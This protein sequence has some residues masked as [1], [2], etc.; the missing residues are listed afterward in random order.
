MTIPETDGAPAKPATAGSPADGHPRWFALRTRA[1]HEKKVRDEV[2]RAGLEAFL[3]LWERWSQWKDRRRLVE[4][5]LFPGYCFARF[6]PGERIRI[7]NVRGVA[8]IV[9]MH[10]PEPVL[11]GEIQA[12]QR[13]VESRLRYDPHAFLEAGMEVEVVR[14]PLAGLR[15]RLLRKDRSTRLVLSVSLIQQAAAVEIHPADV[16]PV[17]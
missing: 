3:P 8:S 2:L 14:G 10:G 6:A 4:F 17:G 1:R 13:L 12:I 15:G 16:V 9:G 5:P 11:D 7:L